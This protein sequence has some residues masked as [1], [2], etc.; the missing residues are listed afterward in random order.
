MSKKVSDTDEA[1]NIM[2]SEEKYR[3]LFQNA[4]D[5]I[6]LIDPVTLKISDCNQ[7]ASELSGYAIRTLRNMNIRDLH[8][9]E[10]QDVVKTIFHKASEMG[11]LSGICGINLFRNN[12]VHIPVELNLRTLHIR[13]KDY[14]LCSVRDI[15]RQKEKEEKLWNERERLINILDSVED[16]IY[17]VNQKYD[18][19]YV[20]SLLLQEFGPV[21]KRKC[22]EYLNKRKEICPWCNN[23]KV[24]TGKKVR[25]EWT[26]PKT[27]K[28]YDIIDIPLKNPDGS[29]SKLSILHNITELKKAE[30]ALRDSEERFRTSKTEQMERRLHTRYSNINECPVSFENADTIRIKDISSGG[31]CLKTQRELDVNSIHTIKMRPPM[32]GEIKRKSL[33]VWSSLKEADAD[34]YRYESGLKF[35]ETDDS[36]KRSME[37]F[38]SNLT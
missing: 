8:P 17:I 25:W 24:F 20:N 30:E 37:K 4:M 28:T 11:T 13:E 19:E 18:I 32:N 21:E 2:E 10:E 29:I 7:K 38:I 36:L 22:Y 1:G 34:L 12:G 23:K 3:I 16:G 31:V 6:F 33:V 14:F 5:A 15:A 27:E 35:I 26:R 9:E